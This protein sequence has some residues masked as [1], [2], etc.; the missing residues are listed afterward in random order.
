MLETLELTGRTAIVTGAGRGLGKAMARALAQAGAEVVCAARTQAQID[1]TVSEIREGGGR[2]IAVPTDVTQ[3]GQVNALVDACLGEF[4]KLDIMIANAGGGIP[5][6]HEFWDFPDEDFE[7]VLALNLKSAFYSARAASKVM[8]AQG[9]G[10]VII[11]VA[12]GTALRG[13]RGFAYPT[14]KGGVISLTKSEALML[15][16]HGIRANTI[17]PGYVSQAPPADEMESRLRENRGTFIPVR[18]L[19]EWWELGPLAVY[20]SSEASRYV[21]GQ[22]FIIDGG[23]L[24]GGIGPTGF[25]PHHE[26]RD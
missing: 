15:W 17:V 6:T 11:N 13:N 25:V 26:L 23:G 10:G 22:E 9:S 14:A 5:A 7:A 24:A 19:G 2:A 20:L 18:R 12:S 16:P 3:S 8:V 4:G 1:Q 21:T